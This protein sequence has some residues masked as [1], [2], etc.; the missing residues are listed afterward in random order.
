[1]NVVIMGCGRVGSTVAGRLD[2][3]G[4]EV[5]IIDIEPR[6]FSRLTSSFG[7]RKL[8]GSATDH[9]VLVKAGIEHADAFMALAHGDNRNVLAS[10]IARH[11]Y[12]V[13]SVVTRIYDPFRAELFGR[14]GLRTFN[15][16][17]IGADLAYAALQET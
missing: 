2:R 14:L 1:M 15:P 8:A 12:G 11:L 5:T 16:T 3:D 10:Q 13:E 17:N 6:E 7:G 4:H 9:R